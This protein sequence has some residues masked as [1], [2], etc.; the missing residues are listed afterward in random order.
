MKNIAVLGA[1]TLLG[2]ELI[3]M[4]E[5]KNFPTKEL[6]LYAPVIGEQKT[7]VFKDNEVELL[8]EYEGFI[9]K[10]DMVFS[11]LDEAQARD[12]I[13]KFRDKA[14]VIDTSSAYRMDEDVPLVISEINSDKMKEH[15][16]IIANPGSTVIQVLIPL[17]PLHKKATVKKVSVATYQ[18]MS[19]HGRDALDELLLELEY[20]IVDQPMEESDER[21]FD[22]P[23]ANNVI[24]QIGNLH[25]GGYTEEETRMLDE[26]RKIVEDDT[27]QITATC[28]YVPL[29]AVDSMAVSVVFDKPLS[30]DEAKKIL[31]DAPGIKL[32]QKDDKYP[33]PVYVAGKDVV[34]VGR[35]RK[36]FGS[37]NGLVM[38]TVMDNLRKAALNAIQ[39][40]E[41]L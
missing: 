24:P 23:V 16:G 21:I 15:K 29:R 12:I 32:F 28:V 40:A 5:Q 19:G 34:F 37:E 2:E 3:K 18:S 10:V 26:T 35:I 30:P 9:D 36:D 31:K 25:E 14:V 27:I 7:V 4:L 6:F 11:C 1:T 41:L 13:S 8:P 38:W 17:Y 22:H 33:M 20:M 39:I